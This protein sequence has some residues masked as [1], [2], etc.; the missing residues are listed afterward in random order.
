MQTNLNFLFQQ[1]LPNFPHLITIEEQS[2]ADFLDAIITTYDINSPKTYLFYQSCHKS[3]FVTIKLSNDRQ[4][5][6]FN[7]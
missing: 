1:L 3:D 7:Q 6:L 4:S 2:K 5:I